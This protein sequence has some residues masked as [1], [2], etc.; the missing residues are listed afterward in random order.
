MKQH[1]SKSE[2]SQENS[3]SQKDTRDV[4]INH[5]NVDVASSNKPDALPQEDDNPQDYSVEQQ[6][7]LEDE[8][9]KFYQGI[10]SFKI[11][12]LDGNDSFSS[13]SD[14]P[15]AKKK[16]DSHQSPGFEDLSK[17]E[18]TFFRGREQEYQQNQI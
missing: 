15:D 14:E 3:L 7:A 11:S 4:N 1:H 18:Q 8:F 10:H 2:D 6:A 13:D 16:K 12:Q 5:V 9:R 17:Q